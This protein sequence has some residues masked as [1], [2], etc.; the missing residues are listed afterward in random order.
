MGQ[1]ALVFDEVKGLVSVVGFDKV[2]DMRVLDWYDSYVDAVDALNDIRALCTA[3]MSVEDVVAETYDKF[4]EPVVKHK[5][6][7][8]R[9]RR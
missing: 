8:H 6:H 9:W 7:T 1:H 5:S 2:G 3:G 4:D